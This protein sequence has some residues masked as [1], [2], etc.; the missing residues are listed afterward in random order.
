MTVYTYDDVHESWFRNYRNYSHNYHEQDIFHR[1]MRNSLDLYRT[2]T[3]P[4]K[5]VQ[6]NALPT[7]KW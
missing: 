4:P 3:A 5:F 2:I 1:D 7:V 6:L